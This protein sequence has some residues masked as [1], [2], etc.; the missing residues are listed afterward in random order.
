MQPKGGRSQ[1]HHLNPPAIFMPQRTFDNTI[2]KIIS[3]WRMTELLCVMAII[4]TLA[5]LYLGVIARAF[6]HVKK[7]LDGFSLGLI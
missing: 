7:F 4:S 5:A 6:I 2:G 3:G 1:S